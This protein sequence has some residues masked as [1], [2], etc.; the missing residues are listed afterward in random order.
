MFKNDYLS[1]HMWNEDRCCYNLI[2]TTTSE[3]Q[4][5]L[6]PNHV[7]IPCRKKK[8]MVLNTL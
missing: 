4:T 6:S 5:A 1:I 8:H 3:M 7:R 2:L